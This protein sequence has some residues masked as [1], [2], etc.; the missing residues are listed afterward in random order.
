MP[1]A[2]AMQAKQPLSKLKPPQ[3]PPAASSGA[4]PQLLP[5]GPSVPSAAAAQLERLQQ[6]LQQLRSAEQGREQGQQ[7]QERQEQGQQQQQQFKEAYVD[8]FMRAFG[9][10]LE[11]RPA[12][13]GLRPQLLLHCVTVR[14]CLPAGAACGSSPCCSSARKACAR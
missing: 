13:S 8:L 11:E 6:R 14:G 4:A 3:Q 2:V 1:R 7:G 5:I 10:D 12:F 9:R